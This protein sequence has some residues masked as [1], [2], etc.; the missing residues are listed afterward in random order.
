MLAI[1]ASATLL[2]VDGRPVSVEV[3]VSSGLPCFNIVGLPDTACREAR[4]RVRAALSS[5]GVQ[6]PQR[7]ITVNLAPS[8]VRKNGA[9]LDLAVAVGVLV[10]HDDLPASAVA[11]MGFLGELGLDGS[12]RRIPGMVPLVDA[13]VTDTAVV[14]QGCGPE[15][16]LVGRHQV[17]E[18][19]T[20][21][22]LLAALRGDAPW[23]DPAVN[24]PVD[25][26]SFDP[27]LADVRGHTVARLALEVAAAGGHHLLLVGPPGAGKTMLARRLP[28]LLP[29]LGRVEALEATRVHSAAGLE[30]P[31]GGLVRRPPLRAPHHGASAVSLIGG[32][33]TWMRPGEISL[34]TQ[35]VLFL[36]ELAEFARPVLDALRQPLEEG[37]VRVCRARA[38]VCYPAHF[39]LVGAMNPCPCGQGGPPGACRCSD[40][41]RLRYGRRLSG[42]LLDRFD[43]RLDVPRPEALQLL[44]GAAGESTATVA[45]RVATARAI[46]STRGVMCNAQIPGWALDVVAA[47]DYD[48]AAM[49]ESGLRSGT[50]SARGLQRVRRV[51][52]TLADLGG[53]EGPLGEGDVCL[54]LQLRA[55][56]DRLGAVL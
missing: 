56:P 54:A 6:W 53:R 25:L 51:A 29:D 46:A 11:G 15:A 47:L 22:E 31:A 9:G 40:A 49:L 50:L 28:G 44:G 14:P 24:E 17:R 52:R 27:D 26:P 48:A 23:P 2:G 12:I 38:A 42:P 37:V 41:S 18:V 36:D 33:T 55:E 7:R 30:L 45:A 39:L 35:G 8:G 4:D 3:H 16:G 43:L 1:I 10:A 5:T 32:G 20:L 19:A 34:A 21:V 13:M